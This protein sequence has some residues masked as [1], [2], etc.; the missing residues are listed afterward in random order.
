MLGILWSGDVR[1]MDWAP[2]SSRAGQGIFAG[3][4]GAVHVASCT[5]PCACNLSFSIVFKATVMCTI[6]LQWTPQ[7][8][9]DANL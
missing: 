3:L 5:E 2:N 9:T 8:Y 7:D 6:L 4:E 1:Y